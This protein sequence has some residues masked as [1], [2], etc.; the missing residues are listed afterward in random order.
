MKW[1]ITLLGIVI[2]LLGLIPIA[3]DYEYLPVILE[4]IPREGM[5]Y[6]VI[7]LLVGAILAYIGIKKR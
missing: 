5:M 1:S 4:F 3:Y 6:N 7:I 2:M